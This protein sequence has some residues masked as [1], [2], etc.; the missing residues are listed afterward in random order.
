MSK[1]LSPFSIE[2]WVKKGLS[3]E[4][5]DY[6]RNTFR[7]IRKEYWME[8]GFSEQESLLLA[9][10]TKD[11]NNKLGGKKSASRPKEEQYAASHR[12]K[13]YWMKRGFSEEE[14]VEKVKSVQSTFS[15]DKCILKYG[16]E[17]GKKVWEDRQC[18][19]QESLT[20]TYDFSRNAAFSM[21]VLKIKFG[22]DIDAFIKNLRETRNV[23]LYKTVEEFEESIRLYLKEN[24][25]SAY[26]PCDKLIKRF[27]SI[28]YQI[29]N[30]DDK[31]KFIEKYTKSQHTIRKSN[32][33]YKK[34]HKSGRLLRSNYEIYFCDLLEKNSI[35]FMID[36]HYEDSN[37]RYDFYIPSKNIYIEIAPLY[38][39]DELYRKKMDKKVEIFGSII[40]VD[41][42]DYDE[43]ITDNLL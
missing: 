41:S 12:R 5:A 24:P 20:K 39:K 13:E 40:L 21:R 43:Y 17:N 3:I 4:D 33:G 23:V 42:K 25:D 8:K 30:I 14:S 18:R 10:N 9:E 26:L 32:R 6:K 22:N 19:W 16:K 31:K 35:E 34:W 37:M 1:R 29:L 7:P 27:P 11:T 28:Q 2:F 15:L 36:G 38:H